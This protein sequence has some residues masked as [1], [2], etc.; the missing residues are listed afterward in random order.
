MLYHHIHQVVQ[1][2]SHSSAAV[3]CC[4]CLLAAAA[5]S[6]LGTFS[7]ARPPCVCARVTQNAST[8]CCC[9]THAR[10]FRRNTY[11]HD[12][13]THVEQQQHNST[14]YLPGRQHSRQAFFF[15]V[16]CTWNEFGKTKYTHH[17]LILHQPAHAAH[18]RLFGNNAP[19]P[20]LRPWT[21]TLL[22]STHIVDASFLRPASY[23]LR[24]NTYVQQQ[25]QQQQW[26][27]FGHTR[28]TFNFLVLVVQN[29]LIWLLVWVLLVLLFC[30]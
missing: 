21:R 14:L 9:F 22:T 5:A 6:V 2:A 18:V 25:Q 16:T 26:L 17:T 4:C 19:N 20:I 30:N 24:C 27:A 23:G 1:F 11:I 15:L 12:A 29:H 28:Y 8:C 10:Y 7:S 13:C 3:N